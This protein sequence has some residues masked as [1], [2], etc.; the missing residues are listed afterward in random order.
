[1]TSIEK[2]SGMI[3]LTILYGFMSGTGMFKF[4]EKMSRFTVIKVFALNAPIFVVL[5]RDLDKVG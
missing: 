2:V 5:S 4:H 3:V 1:M